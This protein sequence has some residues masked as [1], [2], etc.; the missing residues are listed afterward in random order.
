MATVLA[1]LSTLRL[2]VVRS[3]VALTVVVKLAVE[4]HLMLYY[5]GQ[6][7]SRSSSSNQPTL[8]Q[9]LI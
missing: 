1:S 9:V 2:P 6:W 7:E 4:L 5:P 3:A 8:S